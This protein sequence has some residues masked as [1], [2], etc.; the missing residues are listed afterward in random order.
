MLVPKCYLQEST[1]HKW[2]EPRVQSEKV[3]RHDKTHPYK[4]GELS[5]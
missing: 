1:Q 5:T 2:M 3:S 4:D